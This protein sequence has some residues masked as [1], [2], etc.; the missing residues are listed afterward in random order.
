M[1]TS[2]DLGVSLSRKIS[3]VFAD[4]LH[5]SR[6]VSSSDGI[7]QVLSCSEC[8]YLWEEAKHTNRVRKLGTYFRDS[9][10]LLLQGLEEDDLTEKDKAAILNF[11]NW[12]GAVSVNVVTARNRNPS[13]SSRVTTE[14]S[15]YSMR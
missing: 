15:D 1:D 14:N 5:N 11:L 7:P 10:S 4:D 3:L 12:S 6:F 8:H 9:T 13:P 2:E